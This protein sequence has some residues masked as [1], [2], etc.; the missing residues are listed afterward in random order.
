MGRTTAT[1]TTKGRVGEGENV[2]RMCAL[3]PR[4][5]IPLPPFVVYNPRMRRRL[6]LIVLA[7]FILHFAFRNSHFALPS[8]PSATEPP[9]Q[10]ANSTGL[11]HGCP[12]EGRGGGDPDLNRRKNRD[13]PPPPTATGGRPY[14]TLDLPS[15]LRLRPKAVMKMKD[16]PRRQ[17]TTAAQQEVAQ[18]E[19]RGAQVEGYLLNF[20]QKMQAPESCN[21]YS[22]TDRDI[23]LN[24]T[25][26]PAGPKTKSMV[27][28][29]SPRLMPQHPKW[30]LTTL[31]QLANRG[32]RLRIS[33]W[34]MYDQEHFY[35][36]GKSR[37]TVW[38]LHPIHE[39]EFLDDAGQWRKVDEW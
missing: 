38:E 36:V 30:N 12:P 3:S 7:S 24:L 19:S 23:H 32:A 28:E 8:S 6:L 16:R 5:P 37:G 39:I 21:C 13:L 35:N 18:W 26:T 34:L 11:F 22:K 10:P 25:A 20:K 14:L 17:W 1:E 9:S 4:L 15:F 31:Q 27:M 2:F 33:G 29:I